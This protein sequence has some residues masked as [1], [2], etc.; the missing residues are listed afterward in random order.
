MKMKLKTLKDFWDELREH[1]KHD[2]MILAFIGGVERR[3][4]EE[5]IK[6]VKELNEKECILINEKISLI[7]WIEHFF[8]ITEI[9]IE[10]AK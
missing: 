7:N 9:A 3:Q 10:E 5:A 1:N 2:A 4:R 6:W 8:N